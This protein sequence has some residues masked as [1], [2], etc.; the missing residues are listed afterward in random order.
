MPSGQGA[1]GWLTA[2]RADGRSSAINNIVH[3][4]YYFIEVELS[5]FYL[6]KVFYAI[7]LILIGRPGLINLVEK[8]A[9]VLPLC[10]QDAVAQP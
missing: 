6:L 7:M 3:L 5:S 4:R 1:T 10:Y 8:K 9:V 2:H